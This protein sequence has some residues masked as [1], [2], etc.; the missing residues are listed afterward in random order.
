MQQP[1]R[2]SNANATT[3]SVPLAMSNPKP[4]PPKP[5]HGP[6][7][8]KPPKE[9]NEGSKKPNFEDKASA[10]IDACWAC[11]GELEYTGVGASGFE[12]ADCRMPN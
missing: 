6:R 10:Y 12:C 11:G 8:P 9:D 7:N 5:Q 3:P 1:R 4:N 2:S